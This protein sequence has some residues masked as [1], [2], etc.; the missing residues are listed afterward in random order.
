MSDKEEREK[1]YEKTKDELLSKQLS[2]SETYDNSLLSLSSAFLGLSIA[3]IKDIAPLN[4][5]K[6]T[7]ILYSSWILFSLTIII[8]IS[9]FLYGQKG[10]K[11]LIEAARMYYLEND[12]SAYKVSEKVSKNIDL[13]NTL[14]G[15]TFIFA[16]LLTVAFV[17]TNSTRIEN[18]TTEKKIVTE[19]VEKSQPANTFQK[20]QTGN[21]QQTNQTNAAKKK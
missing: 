12:E 19:K 8:V 15:V 20:P 9:S 3:F 5:A 7:L 13:F 2:N 10:I 17:L 14:S 6:C 4:E 21:S 11:E 1:L 16:I 18:M